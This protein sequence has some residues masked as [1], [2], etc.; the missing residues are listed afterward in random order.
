MTSAS[1][2]LLYM[3]PRLGLLPSLSDRIDAFDQWCLR[4]ICVVRWS[5]H[6]TNVQILSRS[7]QQPL[8]KI[9]SWLLLTLFGHVARIELR[10]TSR[11]LFASF[12]IMEAAKEEAP[13][14]MEINCGKGLGP[15]QHRLPHS[16]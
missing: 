10:D 1:D 3:P 16:P 13:L 4:R 11:A 15:S 14:H 6:I 7:S 2:T 9:V 12:A 5:N 8:S